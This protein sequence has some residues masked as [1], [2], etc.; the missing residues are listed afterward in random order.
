MKLLDSVVVFVLDD[1][2]LLVW[3][4]WGVYGVFKVVLECMVE[5]LY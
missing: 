1:L 3:V 2:E 5:I 4:Y